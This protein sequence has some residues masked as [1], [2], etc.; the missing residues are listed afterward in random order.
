MVKWFF[1]SH[2]TGEIKGFKHDFCKQ[3]VRKTKTIF[4]HFHIIFLVFISLI[5]NG[6]K[7]KRTKNLSI[8]GSN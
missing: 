6:Y 8:G 7:A 1:Y 3:K 5:S 4:H 2:V